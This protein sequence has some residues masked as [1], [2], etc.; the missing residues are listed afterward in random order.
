MIISVSDNLV[1][2]YDNLKN[3]GY[4]AYRLS[5]GIVSDVIIYSGRNEHFSSINSSSA[6]NNVSG[7]FLVDGDNKSTDEVISIIGA[8]TY[9]ALF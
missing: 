3:R 6:A 1:Y 8:K 2:L 9:S 7:V 4:R 5:D